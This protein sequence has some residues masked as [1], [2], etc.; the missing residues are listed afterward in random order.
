MRVAQREQL[1]DI[2]DRGPVAC[3]LD[4]GLW[5][6]PRIARV[7]G[8]ECGVYYHPCRVPARADAGAQ[9]RWHRHTYPNLKKKPSRKTGR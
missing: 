5:T 4:S 7:I 2:L 3:G 6:S 9:D 8:E 1:G